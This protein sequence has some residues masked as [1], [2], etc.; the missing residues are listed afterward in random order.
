MRRRPSFQVQVQQQ[1]EPVE[2]HARGRLE[3]GV[4][5]LAQAPLDDEQPVEGGEAGIVG[6]LTHGA[7]SVVT[8]TGRLRT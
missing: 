8:G 7:M 2:R 4:E 5:P 1:L 6:V 3:L